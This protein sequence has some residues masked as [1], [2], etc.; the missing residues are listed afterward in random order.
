MPIETVDPTTLE[1]LELDAAGHRL[2]EAPPR[3]AV[4]PELGYGCMARDPTGLAGI[5]EALERA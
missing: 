2:G 3:R 1:V 5:W 4:I